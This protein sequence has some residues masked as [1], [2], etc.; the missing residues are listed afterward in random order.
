MAAVVLTRPAPD[1]RALAQAI[2]LAAKARRTVGFLPD[3][4]FTERAEQGTLLVALDG[5][6]VVGYALYDLPRDEIRL[7]QL[8]VAKTRQGQGIA[9]ALVDAIARDHNE[10]RGILL[11]CRNDFPAHHMWD[12]L[13]FLALSERPGNSFDRKPLT[14]WFRPFGRPDLFTY[15]QESDSRPLATMDACVFFD[16]VARR[17]KPVAQQLR[18]DWLD[19]HVR[20]GV[21]DHLFAEIAKGKDPN[22]RR[23]QRAE[24]D[25]LRL[26]PTPRATWEPYYER[27]LAAHPDAP[28]KHRSDLVHAAQSIALGATW[29]IT[30]DGPLAR[31]YSAVVESLGLRLV[32]PPAFIREIDQLARGDRY[33]PVDLVGTDVTRREASA[34]ALGDLGDIF[35]NHRSDERLRDLRQRIDVAAA[36]A[37]E[38]RLEV[39]DVDGEPRGLVSWRRTVG[40]LEVGLIRATAGRGETTIARHLLAMVRDQAVAASVETITITDQSVPAAVQRSYRDEGFAASG[41]VVVAHALRGRGTLGDLRRRAENLGSPLVRGDAL[42]SQTDA[43]VARAA[44]AE[45]WFAPY[46][47]LSAGVPSFVLPIR[48]GWATRLLGAGLAEGQ[49]WAQEWGLGLRRELVYYRNPRNAGGL[50][51]P[52]R[53]LWYVSGNEPGAGMIRAT[54][55]LTE[56]AVDEADRLYHRFRALGVYSREDVRDRADER[57]HAMALRFS[58]TE[59]LDE[60]I[61]LRDYRDIAAAEGISV[62]LRSARPVSEH[63]FVTLLDLAFRG[64]L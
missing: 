60:P 61:A 56:V 17:P 58:H 16:L 48:H 24:A 30:T 15:L 34:S 55:H 35:V 44:A 42:G 6:A 54:S 1:D 43:L 14:R 33:R 62:V 4:A 51:A 21:T 36:R 57:G 59:T 39:V 53:L 27:I 63:T 32:K 20:F 29:L 9:R 50:A 41:K 26:A 12:K 18:A 31:R 40:G 52:A 25:P 10:R 46:R 3:S 37:G 47:V 5:E 11:S 49:L 22:E 13:D 38:Q 8:V 64:G 19:E 23:R 45:R 7:V 28:I 2:T